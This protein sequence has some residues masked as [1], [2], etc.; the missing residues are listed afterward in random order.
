MTRL[1]I[2][3]I[4]KIRSNVNL[5]SFM[6][7]SFHC[8]LRKSSCWYHNWHDQPYHQ[9]VHWLVVVII[10]LI[11]YF[12]IAGSIK[13]YNLENDTNQNNVAT[14]QTLIGPPPY[15]IRGTCPAGYIYYAGANASTADPTETAGWFCDDDGVDSNISQVTYPV[16]G[17][18]QCRGN[19]S[20][21]AFIG[22]G[23]IWPCNAGR[24][25]NPGWEFIGGVP[26]KNGSPVDGTFYGSLNCSSGGTASVTIPDGN[27]TA[28]AYTQN[29]STAG[30]ICIPGTELP[31]PPVLYY[32]FPNQAQFGGTLL[33]TGERLVSTVEVFDSNRNSTVFT[34]TL[35]ATATEVTI[36]IPNFTPGNYTVRV[37]TGSLVSNEIPFEV[38]SGIFVQ[39]PSPLSAPVITGLNPVLAAQ[40]AAIEIIGSYLT[41]NIQF[42]DTNNIPVNITG[43]VNSDFTITTATIPFSLLP[44]IYTVG[45]TSSFGS[46]ISQ[47][48]LTVLEG[49]PG[50]TAQSGPLSLPTTQ[51]TFQDIISSAFNYSIILVG[52]AVFIMIMWGGFLWLTSAAN[53][54]NISRAKGIIFNAILG[55]VLLVSAYVI[56]YTINPELVG[57]TFT[58]PGIGAPVPVPPGGDACNDSGQLAQQ[59][60]S[61]FYGPGSRRAPDLDNFLLCLGNQV[62]IGV[63]PDGGS[64]SFY[65]S[66]A[67]YDRS[68]PLCNYTRGDGHCDPTCSHSQNSC[69]YGGSTGTLGALAIDF[70]NIANSVQI[71]QAAL[72]CNAKRAECEDS[73]GNTVNCPG[74]T[75]IHISTRSCDRD[76]QSF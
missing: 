13:N 16:T 42:F 45:I 51:S 39:A 21:T 54:S 72:A 53:P 7:H 27:I 48:V 6:P 46:A 15:G 33:I 70:G 67:S 52:I 49:S 22:P 47:D 44:G 18:I 4:L 3:H 61:A 71:R 5:F 62:G 31:P 66:V 69:H 60:S 55:A 50:V 40:G 63:P 23:W 8:H 59:H 28:G 30:D 20:G 37:G 36:S 26:H 12:I 35:N 76:T 32:V 68:S 1:D 34:G 2:Y 9:H 58:L 25:G 29:P 73:S 38:I 19:N 11:N 75:H 74:G 57:G 65:G 56:L 17:I 64:N 10:V 24:P 41:P 43:T 14:A